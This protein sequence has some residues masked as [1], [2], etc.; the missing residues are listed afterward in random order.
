MTMT[1]IE[2][3][4]GIDP[5]DLEALKLAMEQCR[6]SSR[7]RGRQ[8]DA[9]LEDRPWEEVAQFAAYDRQ[10]ANLRLKPWQEPPCHVEDP[11]EPRRGE[12]HAAKLLRKM[13]KAGLSRW[14]PNPPAALEASER[15]VKAT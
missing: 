14:H 4:D 9:M 8:L 1:T 5:V 13:L 10:I 3:P 7:A 6:V 12:E 11:N 15:G 2:V